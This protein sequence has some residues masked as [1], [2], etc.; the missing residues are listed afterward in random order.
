MEINGRICYQN[1]C[2]LSFCVTWEMLSREPT[3][4]PVVIMCICCS[5][6]CNQNSV[7]QRHDFQLHCLH[8]TE[9][10]YV[11][12]LN[13][14]LQHSYINRTLVQFIIKS[15]FR[16]F[17]KPLHNV[18]RNRLTGVLLTWQPPKIFF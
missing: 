3:S 9:R 12:Y 10:R 11:V 13:P 6:W 5:W 17:L 18:L 2:E 14:N 7:W 8:Q 1:I 4:I 16:E 15:H